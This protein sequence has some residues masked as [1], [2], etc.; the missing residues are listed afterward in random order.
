MADDE[1]A[2]LVAWLGEQGFTAQQIEGALAP[3]LLPASRLVGNDGV[4]ISAREICAETGLDLDLLQRLQNAFGLSRV[5]DPD[6]EVHLRADGRAAAKA[7]E[8]IDLG[9]DPDQ[10]VAV[11][12]VLGDGLSHA[13]EV[14]RQ[15]VLTAVLHPGS[16]EVEIAGAYEAMVRQT[17]PMLGPMITEVLLLQLRHSLETE[18]VN[19]AERAAGTLP[20]AREV[21]VAFAD[22][23]GFTRL[24]E[25]LEP[26]ALEQLASRL[27]AMARDVV[28]PPVR[29]IKTIG[30]AV[31]FVSAEP[32]P[33]LRAVLS[34][35]DASEG[36]DDDFPRL[37]AGLA[38]GLAVSRAGDWYGGVVNLASRITA[39]A[40]PGSVLLSG[41]ARD[42]IGDSDEFAW[43]FAGA[44]HLKGISDDVKLF[45]ARRP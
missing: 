3:T 45:R 35:V 4:Y 17:A 30:D 21:S 10:V 11:A 9:L 32:V 13:A 34:L 24:G 5:D 38:S 29:F 8:F 6:A 26:E 42:A 36:E 25:E 12:R 20:G 31:M 39:V 19:A 16:T 28:E 23:V 43:S 22:L 33:L 14:M 40:R 27:A 7:K 41:A 15:A 18:A 2:E 37:R 44:R 1:R